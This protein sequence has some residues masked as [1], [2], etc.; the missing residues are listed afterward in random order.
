MI[1]VRPLCLAIGCASLLLMQAPAASAQDDLA[2]DALAELEAERPSGFSFGS[3][4]RVVA[5]SDLNGGRGQRHQVVDHGPRLIEDPYLELDFGYLLRADDGAEFRA[6]TTVALTDALFHYDGDFDGSIAIRNAYV[7]AS[8]F[9][10]DGLSVWAGSRMYRGDDIYLLDF[11]PLDDLNTVG[12]GVS[13]RVGDTTIAAHGGVNQLANDFQYQE[14]DVAAP[15]FGTESVILLDRVRALGS[16]RL[17]QLFFD[18]TE[19]T[20][21]KA[22]AYADVQTLGSGAFEDDNDVRIELPADM[23]YTLG[24]QFGAWGFTDN[25]F[26]NLFIRY[27]RGLAAYDEL[28]VPYGF[29]T[30]RTVTSAWMTRLGTSFNA[31]TRL[32]GVTGGAYVEWFRDADSNIYDAD[33]RVDGVFALRPTLFVTRH[34]HQA[35]E[36]S[37]QRRIP[38]GLSA[39]TDTF[40]EPAMWQF[41]VMPTL[42]LDRGSFSRPQLRAMYVASL[43]NDGALDAYADDDPRAG[44]SVQHFLGLGVEWWFNSSYR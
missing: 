34:F 42:T 2:P 26:I 29:D 31:E 24:A 16:L 40:L 20:S 28:A 4:G 21:M 18:V 27:S 15:V 5:G 17:E 32:L 8:R 13:Y 14:V 22:V 1:S 9:G 23:G 36:V 44:Q 39:R 6:L 10:V 19:R 33:D 25:G 12:L 11:W 3:Y 37:Y 43:L 41:G 30:D 7:E 35:F 38:N